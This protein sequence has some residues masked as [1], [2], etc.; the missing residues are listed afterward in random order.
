[1]G[2]ESLLA[3]PRVSYRLLVPQKVMGAT[4]QQRSGRLEF[5]ARYLGLRTGDRAFAAGPKLYSM[6][7][8]DVKTSNSLSLQGAYTLIDQP[9]SRG[10]KVYGEASMTGAW[11]VTAS[12]AG[13]RRLSFLAGPSWETEKFSILGNYARQSSTYLP[14]L[15]YFV[16]DRE[17]AYA[18]S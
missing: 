1:A 7:E 15:G 5:G 4:F 12:D 10:W 13:Q 14:L 17:G 16:G 18:E 9:F 8:R 6:S 11:M 3:G 2:E